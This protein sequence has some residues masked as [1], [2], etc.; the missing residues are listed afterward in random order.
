MWRARYPCCFCNNRIRG[1]F[2][3]IWLAAAGPGGYFE[4]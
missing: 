2:A 3:G 1:G 4:R